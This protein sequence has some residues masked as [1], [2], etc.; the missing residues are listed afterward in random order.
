MRGT[1]VVPVWLKEEGGEEEDASRTSRSR[2]YR[3]CFV[4][5]IRRLEWPLVAVNASVVTC[6]GSDRL[7]SLRG[8]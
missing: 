6:T 1:I 8:M 5:Q 7:V 2:M 4:E 3:H